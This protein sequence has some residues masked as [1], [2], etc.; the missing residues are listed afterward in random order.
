MLTKSLDKKTSK[1]LELH[2]YLRKKEK[3]R[4]EKERQRK[5]FQKQKNRTWDDQ[6]R[7]DVP[8]SKE[9]LKG[10]EKKKIKQPNVNKNKINER[11]SKT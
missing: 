10:P 1:Q 3:E 11:I 7:V 6:K 2:L 5:S 9:F 8:L 4:K